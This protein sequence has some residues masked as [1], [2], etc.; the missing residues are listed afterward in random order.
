MA[1][2]Y[3]W[4]TNR[5]G[6]SL[7]GVMK[8]EEIGHEQSPVGVPLRDRQK[9]AVVCKTEKEPALCDRWVIPGRQSSQISRHISG[10]KGLE[11]E[12]QGHLQKDKII[13]K[14]AG[15]AALTK[16]DGKKIRKAMEAL[17]A[18]IKL[19]SQLPTNRK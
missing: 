10:V 5:R 4:A 18:V 6:S 8:R 7:K 14:C 17:A 13:E 16:T 15:V 19:H 12:K 1:I 9:N 2:K 11:T 3:C